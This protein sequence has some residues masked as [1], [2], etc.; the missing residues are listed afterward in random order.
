LWLTGFSIGAGGAEVVLRGR[1]LDPGLLPRYLAR[2][3]QDKAFEGRRFD[4]LSIGGTAPQGNPDVRPA[5]V[6]FE[7]TA[8]LATPANAAQERK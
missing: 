8:R 6:G 7:I 4:S 5:H 1:M 3:G 2:L